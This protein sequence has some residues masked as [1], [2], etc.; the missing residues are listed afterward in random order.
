MKIK[1]HELRRIV[2]SV[3]REAQTPTMSA[4]LSPD[5]R[6]MKQELPTW[7]KTAHG[8]VPKQQSPA[9]I[10]VKQIAK[11]LSAKGLADD[12]GNKKKITQGLK[13]FIEKM[14]PGDLFVADPDEIAQNFASEVLGIQG[15]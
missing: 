12:A 1:L 4:Q 5:E 13:A 8:E 10:K 7:G 9:D 3:I 15:N 6:E 2:R 14:D 11:I